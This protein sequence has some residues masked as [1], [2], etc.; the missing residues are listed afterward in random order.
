MKQLS[1]LFLALLVCGCDGPPPLHYTAGDIVYIKGLNITGVVDATTYSWAYIWM[2]GS[3]GTL[4]KS[5]LINIEVLER[6]Q[7]SPEKN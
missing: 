5:E 4:V 2:K 1:S 6:V 3:N 7:P